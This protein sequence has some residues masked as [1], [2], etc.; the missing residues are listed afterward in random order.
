M[1]A[2]IVGTLIGGA[3]AAMNYTANIL[4]AVHRYPGS[5]V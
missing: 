1:I 2:V 4:F 3:L 5:Q